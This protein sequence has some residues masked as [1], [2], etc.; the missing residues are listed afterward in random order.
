M[1]LDDF[2]HDKPVVVYD[3]NE[4]RAHVIRYLKEYKDISIVERPLEIADYLVQSSDGTIAVERK[5]ASDFLSSITDGR[6]FTQ[7]EHLQGYEDARIILEGAILTKSKMSA[8]FC[9][10]GLGKPLNKKKGARTQ[11]MTTWATRHFIHPHSLTSIFKK[12]QDMGISI[13]PSG[14][15]FDTADL[16]HFWATKGDKKE[17][18]EIR[19][20][21]KTET[22]FDRQLFIVTGLPNIGAVQAM[23]LL[24]T[25]GT[26][27]HVFSAFM[28]HS[29]KNFPLKG[30]GE[31]KV[32]KVKELLSSN[33]LEV[34]RKRMIEHEFKERI[35]VLYGILNAKK[36]ELEKMNVEQIKPILR[37]RGLKLG[38]RKKELINRL[39]DSTSVEEKVEIKDF[40]EVYKELKGTKDKHHQIPREL[41]LFYKKVK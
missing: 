9:I 40:M 8:C 29:P 27:L 26:P 13:I 19:R 35:D 16:L 31:K 28:D 20:K 41:S 25:F 14:S 21:I 17:H 36:H 34:Q 10:D 24:K 18:L 4:K 7:I 33:L 15:A 1:L 30:L 12:I 5:K 38:G 22:D 23:E 2:I 37:G 3:P 11:P 39:L 32:K 6:M